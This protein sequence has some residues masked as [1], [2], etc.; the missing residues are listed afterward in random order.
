[1]K[2][3]Q[4]AWRLI[5]RH[6]K[7]TLAIALPIF[8]LAMWYGIHRGL[9]DLGLYAI[10]VALAAW[11]I[12]ELMVNLFHKIREHRRQNEEAL[13]PDSALGPAARNDSSVS[14]R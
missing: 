4:R 7:Q 1:M 9:S 2:T 10:V 11:H 3:K 6:W 8:A 13:M 12:A 5:T 14:D